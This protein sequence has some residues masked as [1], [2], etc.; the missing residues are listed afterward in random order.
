MSNFERAVWV[1]AVL[2]FAPAIAA[3][4]GFLVAGVLAVG[5]I[6][7]FYGGRYASRIYENQ[8]VGKKSYADLNSA[9]SRSDDD[10]WGRN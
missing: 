7:V 4:S 5:I 1:L 9:L 2:A 3:M 10:D 6:S 8:N